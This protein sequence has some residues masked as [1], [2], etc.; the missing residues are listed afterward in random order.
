MPAPAEKTTAADVLV[1]T[2]IAWGVEVIFGL[3]GDGING[4]V[5]ALRQRRDKIRFVQVRHEQ[6]A[7]FM[8]C[9]YAKYT[10]RLGV[11]LATSGPGGL[12]LLTGL[13]DAKMDKQPVLAITGHHFHDLI[14]TYAQQDVP[15]DRVFADVAPYSTRVMGPSHVENVTDAA[16]RHA[17]GWHGVAHINF[18]SDMQREPATRQRASERNKPHQSA[19]V[20]LPATATPD[21][22]SLDA[23]ADLLNAAGR[24]TILAGR[25][26]LGAG[27]ELEQVAEALGAP[28]V[29]A[30]LGKAV[31]PDDSPYTTGGTGL[32]GTKPS[33]EAMEGCDALLI[34]GSSFPYIEFYPKP[35]QAKCVQIDTDPARIGLRHAADVPLVAD[36]RAAL[37]GLLPRLKR[38]SDRS[39]LE[40]ARAG[41]RDWDDLME[42]QGRMPDVPMKPQVVSYQI[43]RQLPPD[44]IVSWDSGTNTFWAARYVRATRETKISGSG[45]LASM[46]CALPYANA[47]A[48]AYPGRLSVAIV[49]DGGMSMSMAELATAVKHKLNVKVFVY[50][51]GTLGQIKWEQMLME[52][53]PEYGVELHPIDFAKVAEACG[54]T[55]LTLTDPAD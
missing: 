25:G 31:V 37:R 52:G 15:L 18:P 51:N 36:C 7:A 27:T 8:A 4:I 54:A 28:I 48:V 44:A 32:L 6:A 40:K 35:G 33:V 41:K 22:A 23:A 38:R 50:S 12:N 17:I 30:L 13:Y 9:G 2:L 24:V 49:G 34:A 53:N 26:A 11:C 29:K 42:K 45:L 19:G 10:G 5:E 21:P 43:G 20:S 47:A 55:G 3:P 39:F 46:A 14:D 16:C 1:D